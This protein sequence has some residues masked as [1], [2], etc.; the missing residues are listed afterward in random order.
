MESIIFIKIIEVMI[1]LSGAALGA[2]VMKKIKEI[3]YDN[4]GCNSGCIVHCEPLFNKTSQL[5]RNLSNKQS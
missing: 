5:V 1:S 2:L 4:N 3:I